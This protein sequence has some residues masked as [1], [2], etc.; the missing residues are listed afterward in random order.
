MFI[1]AH[2]LLVSGPQTAFRLTHARGEVSVICNLITRLS[3]IQ[4]S[5]MKKEKGK[6]SEDLRL[7]DC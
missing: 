4:K 6:G 1:Y 7:I 3:P 2:R 5:D